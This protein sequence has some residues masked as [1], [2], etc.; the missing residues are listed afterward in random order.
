MMGEYYLG[1]D[2]GTNSVGYAV[3]DKKYKLLK[4]KGEPMWGSHVF[5]EGKNRD[6]RRGFRTARRR[7]ARRRQRINWVQEIFAPEIGKIDERFFIRIKESM[8][9][10]DDVPVTD[11]YILF[12]DTKYTDKEYF[13]KYPTIHHLLC[14]LMESDATHDVRLVYL[15]VAW[16]V[17]HRG[18]FLNELDKDNIT[19]VTDFKSIYTDLCQYMKQNELVAWGMDKAD[20]LQEVLPKKLN[21]TAKERDLLKILYEGNKPKDSEDDAVSMAMS[22]KLLAGGTVK[23]SKLFPQ[24]GYDEG[25]SLCFGDAEEKFAE[26]AGQIGEEVQWVMALR[27]LYDWALLKDVL[28]GEESVSAGKVKIYEQHR[29]D[30]RKLKCFIRKYV[31]HKYANIF[32]RSGKKEKNYVAYSYNVNSIKGELPEE[33]STQDEFCKFLKNELKG[34]ACRP[35]DADFYQDMMERLELCTFM[36]KQV[37]GENRVIPYQLY[38]H[39]L[40]L[41]L[42]KVSSY[43]SFLKVK[44]ENGWTN[45]DKILSIMSFRIP[46]FVGPINGNSPYAWL[47]RNG[48]EKIRPWNFEMQID[49]NRSEEE[50]IRRMTNK[51][52]YMPGEDVLPFNS[53][54]YQ[55]FMVLNEIN[56]IKVNGELISVD[57]K[58]QIFKL[59]EK[60]RRVTKKAIK[61]CLLNN[62][63]ISSGKSEEIIISGV[64]D[65]LHSSLKSYHDFRSLMERRLLSQE[66]VEKII[67]RLT[68][69]ENRRRVHMWLSREF[70]NLEEQDRKYIA[71][72]KYEEFGR[73]S[74]SFLKVLKGINKEDGRCA[75]IIEFMWDYN[76]NLMQL[77][78]ESK[79]TF[80]EELAKAE[81][82]YLGEGE[83]SLESLMDDLRIANAVR[84]PIYRTLDIVKDVCK[85]TGRAPAKIFLEMARGGGER[86]KRTVSR[87]DRIK[88]LYSRLDKEYNE[89]VKRLSELLD[90]TSDN[91][92][93][94]EVLYLYFL[95]LGRSMYSGEYIEIDNLKNDTLYNVDHIYPQ[96]YVKDDSLDNKVLVTSKENGDKGDLYP[97]RAEIRNRMASM[98]G[99]YKRMGLI[100][101]K[102]YNRLM[103]STAFSDDEK[104]GFIQRQLVETRQSTKA[105]STVFKMR[106]PKSEII[107]VKAGLVSDFRHEF[108]MIKCRVIND[109]HHAKDAYLNI[110]VGNVYDAKFNRRWFR[111]QDKYSLK[112]KT[113]FKYPV[114]AG[115][116]LVW[117]GGDDIGYIKGVLLKNNIHYTRYAFERKGGFFDQT[118]YKKGAGLIPRKADLET[119]K[120]GGFN[121]ATA[122]FYI[123]AR[124]LLQGKKVKPELIIVPVTLLAAKNVQE[125]VEKAKIYV[126]DT[127]AK[128]I[129]K[130]SNMISEVSFPMGLRHIK[131]NTMFSFDG[132]KS[133]LGGK[134]SGGKNLLLKSMVPMLVSS[135]DEAY[136]KKLEA[137][138]RKR[139]EN[140]NLKVD[141]R[142]DGINVSKNINIYNMLQNKMKSEDNC[143]GNKSPYGRVKI[144]SDLYTVLENG[145]DSFLELELS[146]QANALLDILMVFQ[147]GRGTSCDLSAVG[148]AKS[149]A[150]YRISAKISN[151]KKQKMKDVRIIEQSASGLFCSKS[152][153]LLEYV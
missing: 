74:H 121:K 23:V 99:Y 132:Y 136:I 115:E 82:E 4:F 49:L 129:D 13:R 93:Q 37:N 138:C 43:L 46:Y 32:R 54:L 86:G 111:I 109:L 61:E 7:L 44:D 2:V 139:L 94:S 29:R 51:C 39:E 21:V 95:Q 148:G 14:E 130:D 35:E 131:I 17:G 83:K 28:K 149:A 104:M 41:I 52:T 120:Y 141:E 19:A 12:C 124:Y 116:E 112:I 45:A 48:K 142:Y 87:R 59:F 1:L 113:L 98:W 153:N 84:R 10:R 11:R 76:E 79:Y 60:R 119:E 72:L 92:L 31:P 15:A 101:E 8:L 62:N 97:I 128:I 123:L 126:C 66:Q 88:E 137:F 77:L 73:L 133:C 108:N 75:S 16:L 80:A 150:L 5:E 50:F 24:G 36:P 96:S 91:R 117:H 145:R 85:A 70:P 100:S 89:D 118:I 127:I 102:K 56:S 27:R 140:K 71:K 152:Q 90:S 33:K 144:I 110:V 151:W 20:L 65:N 26:A 147:T 25:I 68:Y 67:E 69:T 9:W 6:Q 103:R 63:C 57:A 34:I 38:Y 135:E 22:V 81:Q 42:E 55:R 107:Y 40:K 3:T 134:D 53:L 58:K 125:N 64:D 114:R 30:L 122:S 106:Y 105:L 78:S 18:H 143:R 47:K 146:E